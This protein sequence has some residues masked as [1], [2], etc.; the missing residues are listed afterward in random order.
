M[1]ERERGERRRMRRRGEESSSNGLLQSTCV[2]L[3]S[4]EASYI[5]GR[6]R[7]YPHHGI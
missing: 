4:K 5:G 1:R 6:G 3:S 2:K 7:P